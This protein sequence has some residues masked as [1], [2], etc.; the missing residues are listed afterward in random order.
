[1]VDYYAVLGVNRDVDEEA[2][3]KAYRKHALKW[4]PDRNPTNKAGAEKKFKEI[5]EAYEVL[6]DK[7]KRAIY[8]QFGE[9]GLKGGV[10]PPESGFGGAS[11]ASGGGGGF[12][13]R[14][15]GGSFFQFNS[16]GGQGGRPFRPSRPED[17][18]AQFFGGSGQGMFEEEDEGPF[19]SLGRGGMGQGSQVLRRQ[20]PL[21]L[22]ELYSGCT[23]KLKVTKK[24]IDRITQKTVPT[25]KILTLEIKP[26][27]KSGTK[28][29]FP[30]EGDDLPN[31]RSQDIEFVVEEKPHPVYK[32][33]ND[34]LHMTMNLNLTEALCG[35]SKAIK[36]LDG[37]ELMVSNKA[38]TVPGQEIRL[39]GRGM[40]NQRMPRVKGS[41]VITIQVTFPPSLTDS[42]K[43]LIRSALQ[44]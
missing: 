23:K 32:R 29:K 43:A 18:F 20:L 25:E 35:F 2:L 1:M 9:E 36:T 26:G 24:L 39:A 22:E 41:L 15:P 28:I 42:Q 33:S 5:S 38:V 37:K 10:P 34:D 31:G 13:G 27:W 19:A 4:H 6:S 16:T 44:Q 30:G 3:K 21:T 8:D 11:G 40:P 12:E 17:I 14:F 7:N